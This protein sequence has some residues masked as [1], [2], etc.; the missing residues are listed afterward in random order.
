MVSLEAQLRRVPDEVFAKVRQ[1]LGTATREEAIALVRKDTGAARIV[2]KLLRTAPKVGEEGI[3]VPAPEGV[4]K[5]KGAGV[6]F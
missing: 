2:L 5:S 6:Q 3:A 1:A 4:P